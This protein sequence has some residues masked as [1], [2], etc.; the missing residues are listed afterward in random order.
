MADESEVLS[1]LEAFLAGR[2]RVSLVE[3]DALV[4]TVSSPDGLEKLL[5]FTYGTSVS[6]NA[7]KKAWA[8]IEKKWTSNGLQVAAEWLEQW[9]AS[10]QALSSP[11]ANTVH[12]YLAQL[13]VVLHSPAVYTTATEE[14]AAKVKTLLATVATL[15]QPLGLRR[16]IDQ[17]YPIVQR[18]LSFPKVAEI[19]LELVQV[20]NLEKLSSFINVLV[21]HAVH[22]KNASDLLK[23]LKSKLIDL[24]CEHVVSSRTPP[25]ALLTHAFQIL[26]KE[27]LSSENLSEKIFP[28]IERMIPRTPDCL[29]HIA[30]GLA[31]ISSGSVKNLDF[32][33][34]SGKMMAS[35]TEYVIAS[36]EAPREHA[37]SIIRSLCAR[38]TNASALV[39]LVEKLTALL[40]K[41]LNNWF[42]RAGLFAAVGCIA[43]SA[44][45]E[46]ALGCESVF[47]LLLRNMEKEKNKD[48]TVPA[49]QAVVAWVLVSPSHF[50]KSDALLQALARGLADPTKE[51]V[52][53]YL[54]QLYLVA[55]QLEKTTTTQAVSSAD[56]EV[57]NLATLTKPL[58]HFVLQSKTKSALAAESLLSLAVL[59]KLA[60]SGVKAAKQTIENDQLWTI[61]LDACFRAQDVLSLVKDIDHVLNGSVAQQA[62]IGLIAAAF[63][64][65]PN[66]RLE[67]PFVATFPTLLLHSSAATRRAALAEFRTIHTKAPSEASYALSAL[68]LDTL[69]KTLAQHAALHEDLRASP[70]AFT[71]YF[72]L[73]LTAQL[74]SAELV[75]R[76]LV[77]ALHPLLKGRA[78]HNPLTLVTQALQIKQDELISQ[79]ADAI[80]AYL[81]S[82]AGLNAT[83]EFRVR[84]ARSAI[85]RLLVSPISAKLVEIVY[86]MLSSETSTAWLK[87]TT[88]QVATF[89]TPADVTY[90]NIQLDEIA[91]VKDNK[92]ARKEDDRDAK[93]KAA[94]AK[95]KATELAL[96]KFQKQTQEALA[97][98]KLV[99]A[100]VAPIYF[101]LAH[102]LNI[103][104][105]A[106]VHFPSI[107]AQNDAFLL[108]M[109]MDS[110]AALSRYD[111]E[112]QTLAGHALQWLVHRCFARKYLTSH[113]SHLASAIAKP[114]DSDLQAQVIEDLDH[115]AKGTIDAASWAIFQPVAVSA[116]TPLKWI[117]GHGFNPNK[118]DKNR[119]N[120]ESAQHLPRHVQ[121]LAFTALDHNMKHI[122]PTL[123][124]CLLFAV[125]ASP[126][127]SSNAA[128]S[129]VDSASHYNFH[130]L[131]HKA[132][133]EVLVEHL[134]HEN[135]QVRIAVL[136]TLVSIP[137]LA[138][139]GHHD[140]VSSRLWKARF[141]TEPDNSDLAVSLYK[142]YAAEH[143]LPITYWDLYCPLLSSD[144]AVVRE[145][146]AKAI[147]GAM[148][149]HPTTRDE[150]LEKVLELHKSHY[151]RPDETDASKSRSALS[152]STID[153]V[154]EGKDWYKYRLGAAAVLN[155]IGQLAE[156][157]ESQCAQIFKFL[158]ESALFES[159]IDIYKAFVDAGVSI[160]NLQGAGNITVLLKLLEEQLSGASP[161][162][163]IQH[164]VREAVVIFLGTLAQHLPSTD[165]R[166]D[167]IISRLL[168]V[169]KTPSEPVQRSVASCLEHIVAR[170]PDRAKTLLNHCLQLT[171]EPGKG[172]YAHQRGGAWGLAGLTKG[173]RPIS[174]HQNP[175][176]VEK[177]QAAFNNKQ[178]IDARV[179]ASLSLECFSVT[180]GPG[181]E[182]WILFFLSN[183][184]GGLGDGQVD[185]REVSLEAARAVMSQLS[186]NGVR[187][188]LPSLLA[189]LDDSSGK[190]KA[191]VG[192]IELVGAMGNCQPAQLGQCLPQIVPRLSAL[193]ADPHVQVQKV[194]KEAL[195]SICSTIHNPEVT[196]IVPVLLK[197]IDDPKTYSGQA[198]EHLA[199]TDFINRIDNASLSLIMPVLDRALRERA[200]ETKKRATKIVGIM[201]NLTEAKALIPYQKGLSE[202]LKIVL[203][204]PHPITRAMA[205]HAL[206]QLVK[207]LDTAAEIVPYLLDTMKAPEVGMIERIGAAQGMAH[208]VSHMEMTGF[209]TSLLPRI[210]ATCD[211]PVPAARQG[212]LAVFQFL[213]DTLSS[214]FEPLLEVILPVVIKGLSDEQDMV[215]E[216]ALAG[217]QAIVKC[218][219]DEKVDVLIPVLRNGLFDPNW[220]IRAASIQLLGDLLYQIS[221]ASEDFANKDISKM[222]EGD[223]ASVLASLYLLRLDPMGPV[224]AQA[225]TV[226]KMLVVNTP[227]TLK[228]LMPTLMT[229]II[230][231]LSSG[232]EERAVAS[233]TLVELVHKMGDRV[234]G[235]VIPILERELDIAESTTRVGICIGLASVLEAVPRHHIAE[236][237]DM[238]LPAITKTL[239]DD[240]SAVRIAAAGAF[241]GLYR[242][243][244]DRAVNEC[245]PILLARMEDPDPE[246]SHSALQ[247]VQQLLIMRAQ[248]ILP[249]LLPKLMVVPMSTF[250]AK[251]L[252]SIAEVAGSGLTGFL[253][254]LVPI[255][256]RLKYAEPEDSPNLP[257][258]PEVL[259]RALNAVILSAEGSG[260][261]VLLS[262]LSRFTSEGSP[263]LR[264]A[265]LQ[266][267]ATY[268]KIKGKTIPKGWLEQISAIIGLA[269]R[270]YHDRDA[271]VVKNAIVALGEI[272]ATIDPETV[273]D[274]PIN[275]I[276]TINDT[277]ETLHVPDTLEGFSAPGGLAPLLPIFV[278]AMRNG[279]SELREQVSLGIRGMISKTDSVALTAP[280]L[281]AIAGPLI[282]ILSEPNLESRIRADM[283]MTL[284]LLVERGGENLRQF[285]TTLQVTYIKAVS[286]TYKSTRE[287]AAIG[288]AKLVSLGAKPDF[289][290]KALVP[291][292]KTA[293]TT[294]PE[295]CLSA[296]SKVYA[297]LNSDVMP[298]TAA[299][300]RD[301]IVP[302]M[303]GNSSSGAAQR[304]RAAE[305]LGSTMRFMNPDAI[306]VA[307]K[308]LKLIDSAPSDLAEAGFLAIHHL[309]SLHPAFGT[310]LTQQ[311]EVIEDIRLGLS[312]GDSPFI[313][314]AAGQALGLLLAFVE[315]PQA[316]QSYARSL[317]EALDEDDS[318]DVKIAL[319]NAM[320]EFAKRSPERA[321]ELLIILVPA[322]L[323]RVKK[324]ILSLKYAAERALYHLL[325]IHSDPGLH[326]QFAT[327]L[328]ESHTTT[329]LEFCKHVLSKLPEHSDD[330]EFYDDGYND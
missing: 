311:E 259:S 173:L 58:A 71:D 169:L 251:A 183:L 305:A 223:R 131:A 157:P 299:A 45:A 46:V 19:G 85:A 82:D 208:V 262:E 263:S 247:G 73:A 179:G 167:G 300:I 221:G 312:V 49:V 107:F 232:E 50:L 18:Y 217:G 164:R 306:I 1:K 184:I 59:Q 328:P 156:M 239:C 316:A 47:P 125:D 249:I 266:V 77:I 69:E 144:S 166:A 160:I 137:K 123:T 22:S 92:N 104:H 330:E 31:T 152:R 324:S 294:K 121:E 6:F 226:W 280:V 155:Q 66:L 87:L 146:A 319:L 91:E 110:I 65:S 297:A 228:I 112:F 30:Q 135:P 238:L 176:I 243:V 3:L 325:Q 278:A 12:S 224:S 132:S 23:S 33:T 218:F 231:Q 227:K 113:E 68:L 24:Y 268:A 120:T 290:M 197:A 326:Q 148:N 21:F 37:Q 2:H 138:Q 289:L 105:E 61:A 128:T 318:V 89:H 60:S 106:A 4:A 81:T 254:S 153:V 309:L 236:Y 119:G 202:Q 288:I 286:S 133:V 241:D 302:F 67:A 200:S 322:A 252:A 235:D 70:H 130:V 295:E 272:M 99:R 225:I 7:L 323:Q 242:G 287:Q 189:S 275:Y 51:L 98:E 126:T 145:M 11:S 203:A 97:A 215:R 25:S 32:E 212:Y 307:L 214:R 216:S 111:T 139:F 79:H 317:T 16:R 159:N 108:S 271:D 250:N 206:G 178:D 293:A 56:I 292:L 122:N 327:T 55:A 52:Y 101:S 136:D 199:N 5:S 240:D 94:D 279:S 165:K 219:G 141:D 257:S 41:Q 198:L 75:P 284:N 64:A 151:A 264:V 42:E 140:I 100:K 170:M 127:F 147:V 283:L 27:G 195:E 158:I 34:G 222:L 13:H 229:I 90:A 40:N 303:S 93:K 172:G 261:G 17:V 185:V 209:R 35:I 14:S 255:L 80:V 205:A 175:F 161:N 267:I 188:V 163:P 76:L 103:V 308:G 117:V 39:P 260:L 154:S 102:G 43:Q 38:I 168:E 210:L 143:P 230:K 142:A 29:P 315:D 320:R 282:R 115:N 78:F 177:I 134:D 86:P 201:C 310:F 62:L 256:I 95:K 83:D 314:S 211:S 186:A 285:A 253:S 204:D 207:G 72:K 28:A 191:K 15:L 301:A 48:A 96:A 321:S 233:E 190:W 246:L 54:T 150:T 84:A 194:A 88:A 116:V 63:V 193:L 10:A 36:A 171:L 304:A 162:T 213:P 53:L 129:V 149:L 118:S 298:A 245:L 57:L 9:K 273:A 276:Q 74:N 26:L 269:L 181:F 196:K 265:A 291:A 124:R 187:L 274:S 329:F 20:A 313:R 8:S 234:L 270:S 180:L 182:P 281:Q 258:D 296:I 237:F 109:V 277:I 174:L 220:R 114:G 44:S 244:G 192:A 248:L